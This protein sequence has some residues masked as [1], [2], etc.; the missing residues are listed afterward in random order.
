MV[1]G[2]GGRGVA[3]AEVGEQP[4]P[5]FDLFI[6][7]QLAFGAEADDAGR[8]VRGSDGTYPLLIASMRRGQVTD[9]KPERIVSWGDPMVTQV[10]G[11]AG[12]AIKVS[13]NADTIFGPQQVDAQA[14]VV[15]GQ[16]QGWFYVGSGEEV[17]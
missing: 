4:R 12:Y 15:N 8:P 13:Y 14:L 5:R 1:G 17:P 16:V 9:I 6:P 2:R 3:A 11:K 7:Q 10:Q